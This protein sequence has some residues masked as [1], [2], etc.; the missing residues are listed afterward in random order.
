MSAARAVKQPGNFLK[1]PAASTDQDDDRKRQVLHWRLKNQGRQPKRSSTDEGEREAAKTWSYV[2]DKTIDF[3]T[4]QRL[5][6]LAA[7]TAQEHD[8]V[9]QEV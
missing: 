5:A 2:K 8:L 1:R 4:E 3:A 9:K 7:S 6:D